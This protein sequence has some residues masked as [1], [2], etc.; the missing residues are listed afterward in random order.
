MAK[1]TSM[2]ARRF[3]IGYTERG[4]FSALLEKH[5]PS[6]SSVYF[7]PKTELMGSGRGYESDVDALKL[8]KS[9]VRLGVSPLLILNATCEGERTG[10]AEQLRAIVE[11]VRPLYEAGLRDVSFANLLYIRKFK[12]SYPDARAWTSVN[13]FIR[14]VQSAIYA[15]RAGADVITV[16]RDIN[17]KPALISEIRKA[18]G[19]PI[20]LLLNEGCLPECPW[21]LTHFNALSHNV[22]CETSGGHLL[23]SEGCPDYIAKEPR[24]F[25]RIPFVRPEDL[26]AYDGLADVWK[27]ATRGLGTDR[28]E[29]ILG[30]YASERYDGDLLTLLDVGFQKRFSDALGYVDNKK[31]GEAGFMEFMSK[32]P[33]ADCAECRRCDALI[34]AACYRRDERANGRD[35]NMNA[36]PAR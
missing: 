34:R 30:A 36:S 22:D 31:L 21:R 2:G 24:I 3:S 9:C 25:F 8:V 27:L 32:C 12:E 35:C 15:K 28:I 19:L 4:D 29:T 5:A 26:P 16:D 7:S 10:T 18:T 1:N 17:R 6:I 11:Y 33:E 13:C 20:Q 23:E 14:T